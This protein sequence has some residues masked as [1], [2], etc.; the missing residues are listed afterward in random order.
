VPGQD[1]HQPVETRACVGQCKD[2]AVAR[3]CVSLWA[4]RGGKHR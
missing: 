2:G 3:D 1:D 4:A